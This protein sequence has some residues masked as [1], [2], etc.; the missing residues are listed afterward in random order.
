[1]G[2]SLLDVTIMRPGYRRDIVKGAEDCGVHPH[3]HNR[4]ALGSNAHLL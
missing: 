4:H 2:T 1:M 3:R